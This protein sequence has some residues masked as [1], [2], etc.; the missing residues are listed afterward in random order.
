MLYMSFVIILARQNY[1]IG[2]VITH[3]KLHGTFICYYGHLDVIK[4][5]LKQFH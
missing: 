1:S 2:D 5:R 4:L 3:Y